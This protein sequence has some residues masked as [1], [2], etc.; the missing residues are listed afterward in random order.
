MSINQFIFANTPIKR[1][2]RHF[3]FWIIWYCVNLLVWSYQ[4][5][6]YQLLDVIGDIVFS[7]TAIY[8]LIP[9]F[10]QKKRY[11]SFV[12]GCLMLTLAMYYYYVN[13]L[14]TFG[15]GWGTRVAAYWNTVLDLVTNT[16]VVCIL[17]YTMKVLRDGLVKN[18]EFASLARENAN[19]ELE[20]LKDRVHPHFLFNTLNNIYSLTLNKSMRAAGLVTKLSDV[21]K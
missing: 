3:V 6:V 12:V 21:L 18:I 4:S 20:L 16:F 1:Y 15:Q 9:V 19:A 14:F 8:L 13:I 7:Y 17:L 2:E 10:F 5:I 11:V